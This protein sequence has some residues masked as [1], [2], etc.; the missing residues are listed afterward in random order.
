MLFKLWLISLKIN[1][2]QYLN[3]VKHKMIECDYSNDVHFSDDE[4]HKL[5]LIDNEG[6][7]KIF[8]GLNYTADD[9]MNSIA[10]NNDLIT[11]E[12]KTRENKEWVDENIIPLVGKYGKFEP[13]IIEFYL[14]W[15]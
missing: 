5:Y 14:L 6:N 15:T 3:I 10:L 1:P 13:I 4:K 2:L 11:F 8:F 7:C 9:V 12:D